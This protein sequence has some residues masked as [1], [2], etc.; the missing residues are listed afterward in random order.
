MNQ[1]GVRKGYD[2][3]Q[4][5]AVRAVAHVPLIASGGAGAM[6]HFKDV[7]DRAHVDGA[8][9]ASVFHTA[10]IDIRELKQYLAGAGIAIRPV[11]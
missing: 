8:L 10:A 11:A 4:L 6:P 2:V 7:F 5:A 1:D 3:A 9:A